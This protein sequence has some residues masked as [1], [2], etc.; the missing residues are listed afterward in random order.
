M[1]QLVTSHSLEVKKKPNAASDDFTIGD[2]RG[3][4]SLGKLEPLTESRLSGG[5]VD[6]NDELSRECEGRLSELEILMINH[7]LTPSPCHTLSL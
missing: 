3:G 5:L 4:S 7:C 2:K 6:G 1:E